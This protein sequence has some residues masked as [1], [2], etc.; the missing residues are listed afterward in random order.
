[1]ATGL[2]AWPKSGAYARRPVR[3]GQRMVEYWQ[4]VHAL[5]PP[6]AGEIPCLCAFESTQKSL[7]RL[8]CSL[9][10]QC[11]LYDQFSAADGIIRGPGISCIQGRLGG[12]G[13]RSRPQLKHYIGEP[14]EGAA[15]IGPIVNLVAISTFR[16]LAMV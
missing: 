7:R 8:F 9:A 1:M 12:C 16:F 3:V 5:F 4:Y 13:S 2:T 11:K 14:V 15:G 6:S 10:A